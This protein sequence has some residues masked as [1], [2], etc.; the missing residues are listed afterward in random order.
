MPFLFRL[1]S[2]LLLVF[3]LAII[4]Q[5]IGAT[6]PLVPAERPAAVPLWIKLVYTAF[7]AV[8]V[9]VYWARYGPGNFLWFSDLALFGGL[10]AVWL[11]SSLLASMMTVAVLLPEV[12]WNVGYFGR[13]LFGK[14]L[15]GLS[16]YMFDPSKS[17]F[18]RGLS[19]FHIILP[20]LLLWLLSR[21]G[22][23]PRAWY[24]QTLLA[25]VVLPLSYWLTDP[26]ENVNWVYGPGEKPQRKIPPLLYLVTVML[27]FPV[28]IYLPTHWLLRW[29]FN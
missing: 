29:W 10:A 1:F 23:D 3:A 2:L 16:G 22:Y 19:L 25:G 6:P 28:C 24:C 13:L 7:V 5:A 15:V 9:P 27:F 26:K 20:P 8:L 11:G 12:A 4:L 17:L 21:F 18:L 14:D